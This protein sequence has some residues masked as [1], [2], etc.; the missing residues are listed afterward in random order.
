M[1]AQNMIIATDRIG[2]PAQSKEMNGA[3]TEW[4]D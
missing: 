1:G 2:L 4:G 3:R